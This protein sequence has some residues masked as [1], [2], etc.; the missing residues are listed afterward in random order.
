MPELDRLLAPLLDRP[1]AEPEGMAELERRASR[2]RYRRRVWR[3]AATITVATAALIG[4][5]LVGPAGQVVR[6]TPPADAPEGP[7]EPR[8][9][10]PGMAPLDD[11]VTVGSIETTA[12]SWE[13]R[14]G[15][16]DMGNLCT[17]VLNDGGGQS[18]CGTGTDVLPTGEL[19]SVA[20]VQEV[21]VYRADETVTTLAGDDPATELDNTPFLWG[22]VAKEVATIRLEL[23]DGRSIEV[24]VTGAEAALPVN[25]YAVPVP[26]DGD[27]VAMAA[28]DADRR[29]LGRQ[30]APFWPPMPTPPCLPPPGREPCPG[31]EPPPPPPAVG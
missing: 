20:A 10:G 6:T 5:V 11:L 17:S 15:Y 24:G 3:S 4:A 23:R 28:L 25:F 22:P 2:L 1:L 31:A 13:L 21:R 27:V 29:E 16:D 8:P 14:A 18:G 7:R 12:G 19:F 26:P 9:L 30:T